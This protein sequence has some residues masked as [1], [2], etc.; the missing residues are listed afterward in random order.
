MTKELLF[1]SG[2]F[3]D[4]EIPKEK[5]YLYKYFCSPLQKQFLRYYF[6]FGEITRFNDHT[7]Y[8]CKKP[9]LLMMNVRLRK[10]IRLHDEAKAEMDFEK[11]AMIEMKK[12]IRT[13]GTKIIINNKC[14]NN[15]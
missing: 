2:A 9:W 5:Y 4:Y 14:V 13:K 6:M 1:I 8:Y 15:V 3:I 11:L 12:G 10:L 7:G